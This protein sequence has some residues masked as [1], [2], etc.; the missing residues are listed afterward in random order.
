MSRR[1]LVLLSGLTILLGIFAVSIRAMRT[2]ARRNLPWSATDVREHYVD[3]F[4]DYVYYLRARID[5]D[6]FPAYAKRL[7]LGLNATERVSMD[8]AR[9]FTRIVG[10]QQPP[11]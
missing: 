9:E 1:N 10:S 2:P 3:R 8:I 6:D 4:V 5:K 7:G 11:R